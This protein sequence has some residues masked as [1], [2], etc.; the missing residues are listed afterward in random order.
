M[1]NGDTYSFI[2]IPRNFQE[3][4]CTI[5]QEQLP[6]VQK[7]LQG[8]VDAGIHLILFVTHPG[9]LDRVICDNLKYLLPMINSEAVAVVCIVYRFDNKY[10][11]RWKQ[12]NATILHNCKIN[13]GNIVGLKDM[14]DSKSV[15]G[16][17]KIIEDCS[18]NHD[19]AINGGFAHA[20]SSGMTILSFEMNTK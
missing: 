17:W 9:S 10:I 4:V 8:Y 1:S 18:T 7:K 12:D 2:D 3:D 5:N 19:A 13:F 16:I 15:E 20:S 14:N 6:R 11:E